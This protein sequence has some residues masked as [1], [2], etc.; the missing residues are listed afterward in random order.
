M[1]DCEVIWKPYCEIWRDMI[2]YDVSTLSLHLESTDRLY[3]Y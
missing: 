1:Q 3:V 2:I